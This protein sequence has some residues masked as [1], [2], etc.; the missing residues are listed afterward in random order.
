MFNKFQ[1]LLPMVIIMQSFAGFGNQAF[2][3]SFAPNHHMPNPDKAYRTASALYD[4]YTDPAY[5]QAS[6]N[7]VPC[8]REHADINITSIQ[9]DRLY[10]RPTKDIGNGIC[11]F[12][13]DSGDINTENNWSKECPW[14]FEVD[15]NER[16]IPR[17]VGM[18]VCE[19]QHCHRGQCVPIF[20]YIPSLIEECDEYSGI[21]EFKKHVLE[22][23]VGCSCEK[24][25]RADGSGSRISRHPCR[26]RVVMEV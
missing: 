8:Y 6:F 22:L 23:P 12:P 9:Q 4:L 18:A 26:R 19:C 20:S 25:R 11:H 3:Y 2:T 7:I 5:G 17:R 24:H 10:H 1:T 13:E 14:R 15:Y 16:R 21:C